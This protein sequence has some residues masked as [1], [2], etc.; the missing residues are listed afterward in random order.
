MNVTPPKGTINTL[1]SRFLRC[2]IIQSANNPISATVES[3]DTSTYAL[4]ASWETN[5]NP[6]PRSPDAL[7]KIS[8]RVNVLDWLWE[9]IINNFIKSGVSETAD[10][11]VDNMWF[12]PGTPA[13]PAPAPNRQN[14]APTTPEGQNLPNSG[15]QVPSIPP[16]NG[17]YP[18]TPQTSQTSQANAGT[19]EDLFAF[20][21]QDHPNFYQS[22]D[23]KGSAP[24]VSS[25]PVPSS[26]GVVTI[27][28][29]GC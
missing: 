27:K 23:E 26:T 12:R 25:P 6:T 9:S 1:K 11:T 22:N 18:S 21:H 4:K 19:G 15:Q 14:V 24:T 13:A 8:P 5:Q 17:L 29:M 2:E 20:A 7:R 10:K 28:K 16:G 3:R